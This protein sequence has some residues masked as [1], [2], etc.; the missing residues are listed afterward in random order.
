MPHDLTDLM[1]RAT[2]S[3]P[4]EPYSAPE[5]VALASRRLRRRQG[6]IAGCVAVAVVAA[7]GLGYGVTRDHGTKP[8]PAARFKHDQT[9]DVSSA[10]S[11]SSLPGFALQP[12][13]VPSVQHPGHG[14]SALPTYADIDAGGRLIVE[15]VG[16]D[17]PALIP[18][19]FDGPG[20]P[21]PWQRPPSPG[22]NGGQPVVY[23]PSFLPDGRLLWTPDA[24]VFSSKDGIHLTDL[25]GGN[26]VFVRTDQIRPWVVGQS[27][28]YT[29]LE[30]ALPGQDGALEHTLDT[31]P[32][33]GRQT[34]VAGNVAVADVADGVAVWVTTAGQLMVESTRGGPARQIT[35]PLSRGCRMPSTAVMENAVGDHYLAVSRSLIALTEA[36]GGSQ[37]AQQEMLVLDL[38]GHLLAHVTG[39]YDFNPSLGTSALVFDAAL[40][41]GTVVA[42]RYDLLTGRLAQLS[43]RGTDRETAPPRAAGD[44]VLWYDAQGGHVARIP[45]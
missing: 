3:A 16:T 25:D 41:S 20:L 44:F 38:D 26:D 4:P 45:R 21:H 33:G 10:V 42:L 31:A 24:R 7:A 27:L 40:H 35:V 5:I 8:E 34:E 19:L 43:G 32:I 15:T 29:V 37:D 17:G 12:W 2:S 9:V 1:E 39:A 18:Q 14:Y 23:E 11:A 30:R 36:C 22:R 6:G 28:W 13:Q